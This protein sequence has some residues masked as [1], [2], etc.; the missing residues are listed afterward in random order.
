MS[1]SVL[2]N[3]HCHSIFSDGDQT[4]EALAANFVRQGV[5]F[6]ALTDHDTL[7]GLPRFRKAAAR[8]SVP[9]KLT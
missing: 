7:E 3:F 9:V 5:R 1:S 8:Q 6:A 2:V 4:P